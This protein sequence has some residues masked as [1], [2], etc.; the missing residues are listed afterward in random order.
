MMEWRDTMQVVCYHG[1]TT[2]SNELKSSP[3]CHHLRPLYKA[4]IEVTNCV[5]N[6]TAAQ[7]HPTD[8]SHA[9]RFQPIWLS[10][11]TTELIHDWKCNCIAQTN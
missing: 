2:L 6:Y 7:I 5:L 11:G 4:A 3:M 1:V 10:S 8:T 9:S